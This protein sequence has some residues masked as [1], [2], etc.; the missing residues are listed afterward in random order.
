VTHDEL[1]KLNDEIKAAEHIYIEALGKKLMAE[2]ERKN[3]LE[4]AKNMAASCDING[5]SP[6]EAAC[7]RLA[8][9]DSRYLTAGVAEVEAIVE[10]ET[11]RKVVDFC[12]RKFELSLAVFN[13][14]NKG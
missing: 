5:K 14:L 3:S 8:R 12:K 4:A 1:S 10:F 9:Q 6:S 7:D 13:S 11:A 2:I